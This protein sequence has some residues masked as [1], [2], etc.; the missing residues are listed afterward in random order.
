LRYEMEPSA[1]PS[2]ATGRLYLRFTMPKQPTRLTVTIPALPTNAQP[3]P[4]LIV[5]SA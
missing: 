2:E 3:R 5:P 4:L 1:T